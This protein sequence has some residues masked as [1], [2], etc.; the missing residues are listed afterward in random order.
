MALISNSSG[1]VEVE[2][3]AVDGGAAA[4]EAV[5]LIPGVE[6]ARKIKGQLLVTVD[7]AVTEQ[8][9]LQA[10]FTDGT[11]PAALFT[12]GTISAGLYNAGS[13]APSSTKRFDMIVTYKDLAFEQLNLFGGD[14]TPQ[15]RQREGQ[16]F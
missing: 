8:G 5:T 13:P 11:I 7:P 6:A 2:F 16:R 3:E 15:E 12:D 10:L 9:T 4:I 14:F 1:Q